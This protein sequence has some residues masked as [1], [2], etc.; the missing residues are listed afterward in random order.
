MLIYPAPVAFGEIDGNKIN[1]YSAEKAMP[2]EE[3]VG[4][5]CGEILTDSPKRGLLVKCKDGVVKLTSVQAS[6][7]KRMSGGDFLN[8]RKVKKGQ[9]FTC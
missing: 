6:G 1:V 3:E 5:L 4:A 2:C 7:G 8:G 9:V